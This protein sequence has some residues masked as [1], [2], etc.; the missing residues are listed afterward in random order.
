MIS[1]IRPTLATVTYASNARSNANF[2]KQ[3]GAYMDA[4]YSPANTDAPAESPVND[5]PRKPS[6][7]VVLNPRYIGTIGNKLYKSLQSSGS[8]SARSH[9]DMLRAPPMAAAEVPPLQSM[10]HG[11]NAIDAIHQEVSADNPIQAQL[12]HR[13]RIPG[14]ATTP[15]QK[16]A[17]SVSSAPAATMGSDTK[18]ALRDKERVMVTL[19]KGFSPA[20]HQFM[21]P[22]AA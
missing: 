5:Q 14:A 15:A 10:T 1:A 7:L 16:Q 22:Y 11:D 13:T 4:R 3:Y 17:Q 20:Y 6:T 19:L 8:R 21:G 9:A 2:F 18:R 12:A